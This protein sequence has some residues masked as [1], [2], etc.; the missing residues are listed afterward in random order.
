V[1]YVFL[2]R[3]RFAGAVV[4]STQMNKNLTKK[5]GA[6]LICWLG[7]AEETGAEP[8]SRWCEQFRRV[9]MNHPNN[10]DNSSQNINTLNK[11]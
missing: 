8:Q 9:V 2:Q 3:A 11:I 5:L 10:S 7:V 1:C 4:L 6:T